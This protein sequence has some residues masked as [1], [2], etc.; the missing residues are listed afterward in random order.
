MRTEPR[1]LLD[2]TAIPAQRGGVGRYVDSLVAALD[3]Q[4]AALSVVCQRHDA[5][6][7]A[8]LAPRSRI[9]TAA[10]EL[11]SRPARL[12]WEQTTLPRLARRLPV[13]VIHSPHYTMPMASTVPC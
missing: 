1:V 13:D 2:A 4:G 7:F 11:E 3:E 8:G 10:E 6:V 12:A 5:D 9:I